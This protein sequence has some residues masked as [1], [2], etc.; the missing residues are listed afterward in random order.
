MPDP[1]VPEQPSAPEPA[2]IART[3]RLLLYDAMASEAMSTLATGVFLTGFALALGASNLA[4]GILAAVPAAVQFLQFPAVIL[5]ERLRRRRAVCVWAAGIGRVF[6]VVAACAPFLP[7]PAGVVLLI[8][9]IAMWQASAA[10]AGCAWNSWM[11]DLVPEGAYG[12]FFG[13]RA[14]ANT[15][16]AMALALVCGVLIDRWRTVSPDQSIIAYTGLFIISAAIGFLGVWLLSITPDH[17]MAPMEARARWLGTLGA[18][19]RDLNFRRLIVFLASWNFAANLASP[20]FA[21]YM[22]K[23]LGYS[24]TTVVILTTAS[25][26]SNLVAVGLWGNLI[27]RYSNKA[28][29]GV[30]A[31]LYLLCT[32]A[33][34]LTGLAWV[35]PFIFALLLAIHVLMGIATAGVA[36]ASGNIAMKLSPPGQATSYLAASSVVGASFAAL[37]PVIGGLCADFFAVHELTFGF[38]WKTGFDAKTVEVLNLH[39]WTFFFGLSFLVGLVS[40]HRLS[41][42]QEAARSIN[43]LVMRDILLEARDAVRGLSSVAG[44][45]RVSRLP[46]WLGRPRVLRITSNGAHKK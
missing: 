26:F 20:F 38:T 46:S 30:S 19:F 41:F 28:V 33:W 6:L 18:P 21:V 43:R 22:L 31:P 13:R 25:Q 16:V 12:R 24:M 7:P 9:S 35:A 44:L 37:A 23:S 3:F 2:D 29:L 36:L 8:A 11:R 14:A 45:V 4:I 34:T 40:L 1:A 15:A 42:V 17:P 39:A 32:L 10:I 27:D 5:V